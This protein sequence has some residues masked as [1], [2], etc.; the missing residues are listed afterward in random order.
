MV[1]ADDADVIAYEPIWIDGAVKGFCTSGGYSHYADKSVALGLIPTAAAQDGLKVQIEILGQMR[2][3]TLV[4]TFIV[5]QILRGEWPGARSGT[6]GQRPSPC[7][8]GPT[9]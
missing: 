7:A 5:P 8:A 9:G 2:D 4:T 6:E 3:A 1:D